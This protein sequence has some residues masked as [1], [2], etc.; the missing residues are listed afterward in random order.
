VFAVTLIFSTGLP[1]LLPIAFVALFI[2]YWI[3]KWTLLRVCRSPWNSMTIAKGLEG[4]IP[5]AVVL[6]CAVGA[7]MLSNPSIFPSQETLSDITVGSSA[8]IGYSI[9]QRIITNGSVLPLTVSVIALVSVLIIK[10]TFQILGAFLRR[11]LAL[12]SCGHCDLRSMID[13]ADSR[14]RSEYPL[15]PL[16]EA[17]S[18]GILRGIRSYNPVHNPTLEVAFAMSGHMPGG[19]SGRLRDA[20]LSK[21]IDVPPEVGVLP[22]S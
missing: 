9:T 18:L 14:Y 13:T 10:L 15:L 20:V 4:F 1:L 6:H 7:W 19:A 8:A 11:T 17:I 16:S 12:L 21:R 3:D 5:F 2:R 22:N